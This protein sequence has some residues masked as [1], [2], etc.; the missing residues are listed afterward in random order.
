MGPAQW[1]VPEMAPCHV[2]RRLFGITIAC[3][4]CLASNTEKLTKIT[5]FDDT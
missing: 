2:I 5:N 1:V 4:T 3:K